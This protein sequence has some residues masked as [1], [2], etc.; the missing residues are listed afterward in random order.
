M[1]LSQKVLGGGAADVDAYLGFLKSGGREYPLE[2]LQRAG[3][4]LSTPAPADT[5][6]DLFARRV[7]EPESL[8]ARPAQGAA[9]VRY[10]PKILSFTFWG[11]PT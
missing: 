1:A 4:D 5:A 2:T 9:R 6:L 7:G 3:V 10:W 11:A 8:L